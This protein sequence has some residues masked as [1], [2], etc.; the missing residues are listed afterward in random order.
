M[1]DSAPPPSE[2]LI[3]SADQ[4][5]WGV[6]GRAAEFRRLTGKSYSA[7]SKEAVGDASFLAELENGRN[8]TIARVD[9]VTSYFDARWPREDGQY[10]GAEQCH[11]LPAATRTQVAGGVASS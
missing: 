9:E 7:I 2:V 6:L 3:R 10:L 8:I 5:R 4:I 1:N 11:P